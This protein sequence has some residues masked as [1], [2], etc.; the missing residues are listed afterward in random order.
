MTE[1][2]YYYKII[3]T[4]PRIGEVI[5]TNR[6]YDSDR[7]KRYNQLHKFFRILYNYSKENQ[8]SVGAILNVI[9]PYSDLSAD[10][11]AE[12]FN[13]KKRVLKRL[14]NQ[15]IKNK[16]NWSNNELRFFNDFVLEKAKKEVSKTIKVKLPNRFK[17]NYFF[18]TIEDCHRY[19]QLKG[20]GEIIKVEF[21]K[22]GRIG[23]FDNNLINYFEDSYTAE[24]LLSQAK[25]FLSGETIE[26]P[27]FEIVFQGKYKVISYE[28]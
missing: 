14:F 28:I 13:K 5:N 12:D 18:E 23:K 21:V 27:H 17:S 4:L 25:K 19:I 26:S 2:K 22:V 16:I 24:D 9:C 11:E 8:I 6:K 7:I 15:S 3:E 1:I 20:H 10:F